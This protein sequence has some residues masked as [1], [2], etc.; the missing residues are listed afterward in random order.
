MIRAMFTGFENGKQFLHAGYLTLTC[1][2]PPERGT[3]NRPWMDIINPAILWAEMLQAPV[4][5]RGVF[6]HKKRMRAG[7]CKTIIVVFSGG[8]FVCKEWTK[9]ILMIF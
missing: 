6:V 8:Q 4:K 9:H 2:V 5:R 3:A 7:I 1:S